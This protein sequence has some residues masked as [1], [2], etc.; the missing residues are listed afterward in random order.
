VEYWGDVKLFGFRFDRPGS[1]L[2]HVT[3]P[4]PSY[5]ETYDRLHPPI[6]ATVCAEAVTAIDAARDLDRKA[7]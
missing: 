7:R 3:T 5:G 4:W 6:Q 1:S 2:A